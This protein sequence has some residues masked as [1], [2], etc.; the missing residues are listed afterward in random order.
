MRVAL[1]APAGCFRAAPFWPAA[2]LFI[3]DHRQ[4]WRHPLVVSHGTLT[5]LT[6]LVEGAVSER[7]A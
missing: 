4:H 6:K 5:D 2:Q 7:D 1:V 3:A